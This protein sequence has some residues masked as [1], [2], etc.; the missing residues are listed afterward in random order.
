MATA[1]TPG[2]GTA[3]A[4]AGDTTQFPELDPSLQTVQ[5]PHAAP[6]KITN[7]PSV[8]DALAKHLGIKQK[9]GDNLEN[10]VIQ[11]LQQLPQLRGKTPSG[12]GGGGGGGGWLP[13]SLSGVPGAFVGD[14]KGSGVAG[15]PGALSDDVLA[16][17]G[18]VSGTVSGVE[19]AFENA[20]IGKNDFQAKGAKNKKGQA[21]PGNQAKPDLNKNQS[22]VTD[23]A[24]TATQQRNSK[25]VAD[26]AKKLGADGNDFTAIATKLGVDLAGQ[27]A[28]NTGTQQGDNGQTVYTAFQK[29]VSTDPNYKAG[30]VAALEK[31]NLLDASQNNGN[32][33]NAHIGAAFQQLMQKSV[34]DGVPVQDNVVKLGDAPQVGPDGKPIQQTSSELEAFVQGTAEKFG[35]HLTANQITTISNQYKSD[36][37]SNGGSGIAD[38]IKNS[39]VQYFNP[40]DPLNPPGAAND[41]YVKIQAAGL[42]YGIPM[43][44]QDIAGWVKT[45]ITNSAGDSYSI[46]QA[47]TNVTAAA[48]Q[49]F[50][51]LA[52]GLYPTLAA[53]IGSGQDV[54]TL[55]QPYNNITAQYTGKDPAALANAGIDPT[56][57]NYKFLQ[58]G[59]DA[60]TGAPT[61]MTMDAWKKT[62]MTDP[63]YGFQNT[64]G[65]HDMASQFTSALL[66]AFGKVKTEGT[67]GGFSGYSNN[68]GSANT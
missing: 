17:E 40:N 65:A 67:P 53:Q 26:I 18:A 23:F 41:M 20:L 58:G 31:A 50:Q 60:K 3:A 19:G 51:Q 56:G 47:A 63:T 6:G 11:K 15:V 27:S 9:V 4:G 35:I 33:D 29:K 21:K 39:V 34:T 64:T 62:L 2:G 16:V 7:P 30:W 45:G 10:L 8:L 24:S 5:M 48:E 36:A 1:Y 55:I 57:P 22:N 25:V 37:S 68:P 43:S 32:P 14:V 13:E 52:M 44:A 42:K 46:A 59:T 38:E 28:L 49:H 12:G 61:M 54:A 66:N